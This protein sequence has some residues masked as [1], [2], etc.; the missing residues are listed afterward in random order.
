MIKT[1]AFERGTCVSKFYM[2]GKKGHIVLI[3]AM[4]TDDI[5]LANS[6]AEMKRF[7]V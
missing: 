7:L 3:A 4:V 1:Y 5:L 6:I 2:M